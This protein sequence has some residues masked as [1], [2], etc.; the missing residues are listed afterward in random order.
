MFPFLFLVKKMLPL[1]NVQ[2]SY[3]LKPERVMV[4]WRRRELPAAT[5]EKPVHKTSPKSEK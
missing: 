4:L 2:K 3:Q 1:R 5:E